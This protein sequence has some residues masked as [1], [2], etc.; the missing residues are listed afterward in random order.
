MNIAN[1]HPFTRNVLNGLA[2]V[3]SAG[4]CLLLSPT[5][6][7]GMEIL[8]VGPSWLVM[9]TIVWSLRRSLWQAATAG[10]VLGLIQDRMTL[11]ASDALG[12]LPS[13]VLSLTAVG[14]MTVWLEKRR[15]IDDAAIPATIA[16]FLLTI[17]NESILGLQ[18]LLN[19]RSAMG[20]RGLDLGFDSLSY[21][22]IDRSLV[23]LIAATLSALWMP[24]LYYPLRLWWKRVFAAT[25]S[26]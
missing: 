3:G 7:A 26:V 20:N 19:G 22:W 8:G 21:L 14:V 9:W 2:I 4:L 23:I 17:V 16:A 11:P 10:I 5:R 15:Y 24:L 18:Y 6:F 25:K 13:H 1:L 12:T